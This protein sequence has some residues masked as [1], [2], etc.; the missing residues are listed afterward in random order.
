MDAY[1]KKIAARTGFTLVAHR[2]VFFC[3]LIRRE[4]VDLIGLLDEGYVLGNF[5]DD[6]YCMRATLAGYRLGIV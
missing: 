1:A 3:V 5:E 6:D 2:L 4:L